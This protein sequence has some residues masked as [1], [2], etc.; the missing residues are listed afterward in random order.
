MWYI[1][2]G[3]ILAVGSIFLDIESGNFK[4]DQTF[5]NAFV[6]ILFWPFVVYAFYKAYEHD[7][8]R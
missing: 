7:K 4:W 2:I 5:A 6:V 8:G 3:M 1:T